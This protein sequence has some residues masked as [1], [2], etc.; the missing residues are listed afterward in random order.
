MR[1][2]R[3]GIERRELMLT[4]SIPCTVTILTRNSAA[5]LSLCLPGLEAFAEIIVLDGNSIDHTVDIAQ[6][7]GCRVL[8]QPDEALDDEG[9]LIDYS[10]A[11]NCAIKS[12]TQP[13]VL[14]IDSDETVSP[15]LVEELRTV[16]ELPQPGADAFDVPFRYV[17]DN[18]VITSASTYPG[19]QIRVLRSSLRYIRPIHEV[20]DVDSTRVASLDSYYFRH[21]PGPAQLFSRW[22]RY[23][24][25]EAAAYS[26]LS[27]WWKGLGILRLRRA[28]YVV[29][30]YRALPKRSGEVA[31]PRTYE[32]LRPATE[33]GLIAIDA[34][35]V[36]VRSVIRLGTRRR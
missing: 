6:A 21:P 8:L 5:G 4:K 12:A 16:L 3:F 35:T 26:N 10:A 23:G 1:A 19:R 27:A 20:V 2:L 31:M 32:L 13:W 25:T 30:N 34:A 15:E 29:R 9:R 33:I 14:T 36:G 18:K 11:R 28:R 22:I 7:A 17:I 24:V